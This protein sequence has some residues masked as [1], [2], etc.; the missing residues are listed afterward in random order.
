MNDATE[1][2]KETVKKLKM[3]RDELRLQLKLSQ[4]GVS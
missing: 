1:T 4:H 2:L 3:E